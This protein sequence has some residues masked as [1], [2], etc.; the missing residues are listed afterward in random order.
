[1]AGVDEA[2]GLAGDVLVIGFGR[3]GQ[4]A[5][6]AL[7]ARDIS[8][9]IIETD[10]DLIRSAAKFGFKVYYGDGA[11]LD[12][13]HASGA[14]KASAIL[15]CVDKA[16]TATRIVEIVKEAFPLVPVLARAYDRQHAIE[17]HKRGV[18]F[19]MRETFE[20]ALDFGSEAL[21]RLGVDEDEVE[22]TS[23]RA[24]VASTPNAWPSKWPTASRT[25]R[26][27][28]SCA[29]AGSRR[30]SPKPQREGKA[31]NPAARD[32]L[33]GRQAPGNAAGADI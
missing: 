21:R 29:S 24:S 14:D 13:L 8:V 15:V 33:A 2:D 1:M 26:R 6:Q 31:L 11:R 4:I 30:R 25:R 20:S 9:S 18:D 22:L 19:Q 17:L 5:S 32:A 16:E 27:A 12:V 10:T 3:F 7:M 28:P 23:A